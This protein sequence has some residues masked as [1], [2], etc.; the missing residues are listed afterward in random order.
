MSRPWLVKQ[1]FGI[2]ADPAPSEEFTAVSK[3][4]FRSLMYKT[5]FVVLAF[6]NFLAYIW[7]LAILWNKLSYYNVAWHVRAVI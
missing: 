6:L 7:K 4:G 2:F 5:S 3:F 1:V